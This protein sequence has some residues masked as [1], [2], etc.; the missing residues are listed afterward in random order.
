[1]T[2]FSIPA[3]GICPEC[4]KDDQQRVVVEDFALVYCPHNKTGAMTNTSTGTGRWRMLSPITMTEFKVEAAR[5][6]SEKF[7]ADAAEIER[8]KDRPDAWF[9]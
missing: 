5:G 3:L 2:P 6:A 7:R 1:M 4:M 9:N 8:A